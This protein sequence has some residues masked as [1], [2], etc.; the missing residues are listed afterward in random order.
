[1]IEIERKENVGPPHAIRWL[2][3]IGWL[4]LPILATWGVVEMTSLIVSLVGHGLVWLRARLYDRIFS[5]VSENL[6][7]ALKLFRQIPGQGCHTKTRHP[8]D[9]ENCRQCKHPQCDGENTWCDQLRGM[10]E[11]HIDRRHF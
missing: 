9:G 1:M 10:S 2:A 6:S 4:V 3:F 8:T 7:Q 5:L 11:R